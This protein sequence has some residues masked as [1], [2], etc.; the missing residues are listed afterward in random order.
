[1]TLV[2]GGTNGGEFDS[3]WKAVGARQDSSVSESDAYDFCTRFAVKCIS[4]QDTA[5]VTP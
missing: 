4:A 1:M 5:G 2:H 3:S